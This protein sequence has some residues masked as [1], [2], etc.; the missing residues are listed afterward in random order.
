MHCCCLSLAHTIVLHALLPIPNHPRPY[1]KS[2]LALPS[3]VREIPEVKRIANCRSGLVPFSESCF[4][5]YHPKSYPFFQFFILLEEWS[6]LH[7]LQKFCASS[8]Q[9]IVLPRAFSPLECIIF[10]V[11]GACAIELNRLLDTIA[12]I[13]SWRCVVQAV[14]QD[15]V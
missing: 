8:F 15:N 10:A 7:D 1:H 11:R 5:F 3:F 14:F 4:C 13:L 12:L 2:F 6:S 9:S